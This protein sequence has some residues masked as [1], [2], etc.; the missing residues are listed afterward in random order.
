MGR[1]YAYLR[2]QIVPLDEA[3]I[4][5]MTHAFNYGTACFEGIRANWN[6]EKGQAFVFRPKDH[7]QR[8]RRSAHILQME[9]PY[10]DDELVELTVDLVARSEYEQDVYVRPMVYKSSEEL[11]VRLHGLE[12]DLL[13]FVAPFGAYL[14]VDKGIRCCTS[15]WRRVDDTGIPARAKVTGIYVNSALAKTEAVLDGYDEAIMLNNDGHVSEGSGENIF[16]VDRANRRLI[17]PPPSDNILV[18]ITRESIIAIAEEQLGYTTLERPIDRTELYIA[19]EVFMTGTAAHVSSVV[20]V[21]RRL[22]GD[23]ETGSA[24]AE[25]Q[26]VYFATITGRNERYADWCVPVPVAVKAS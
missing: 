26:R 12:D 13:I 16:L 17:T 8:L 15:S 5:V 9:L 6:E 1:S 22:V 23:G 24:T 19:D 2:R 7:Y 11:G 4:G 10:T 14:D 25:L 21:D 20:E 18:G 3:K